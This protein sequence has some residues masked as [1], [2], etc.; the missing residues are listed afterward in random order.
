MEWIGD[1]VEWCGRDIQELSHSARNDNKSLIRWHQTSTSA[2]YMA[3]DDDDV[4]EY[5]QVK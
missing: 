1:V 5:R 3:D 4:I 2:W